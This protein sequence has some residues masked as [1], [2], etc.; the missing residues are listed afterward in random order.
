MAD[1]DKDKEIAERSEWI[2]NRCFNCKFVTSH[3]F[4]PEFP[5]LNFCGHPKSLSIKGGPNALNLMD[6]PTEDC[7]FRHFEERYNG[8]KWWHPIPRWFWRIRLRMSRRLDPKR[9]QR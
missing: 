7:P 9:H 8:D 5:P 6:P 2:P 1:Y 3:Q 4:H